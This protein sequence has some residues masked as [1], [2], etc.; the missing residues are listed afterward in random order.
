MACAGPSALGTLN[1]VGLQQLGRAQAGQGTTARVRGGAGSWGGPWG[2]PWG[3][4]LGV[5]PVLHHSVLCILSVCPS[6]THGGPRTAGLQARQEDTVE[7]M[8]SHCWSLRR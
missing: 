4:A 8:V 2:G 3:W 6:W 7:R 5:S 1:Q